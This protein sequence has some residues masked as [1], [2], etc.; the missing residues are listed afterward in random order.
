VGEAR[1]HWTLGPKAGTQRLRVHVGS[2][3]S[4]P[5]LTITASALA[6]N[7]ARLVLVSGDGQRA[8]AGDEL[9]KAIA[10]RVTDRTSNPVAGA[11]VHLA[12]SAGSV[13]DTALLTDSLGLAST[14]WTMGRTV[15]A[16]TLA[17]SVD[18]VPPLRVSARALPGAPANLSFQEPP[19]EGLPGRALRGRI[20]AVVT[21][22]YGNP[23]PNAVVTFSTRSGAVSPMRAAADTAGLVRATWT[24]GA[25]LGEQELTGAVRGTDVDAKLIVQAVTRLSAPVQAGRP[26]ASVSKPAGSKTPPP[27]R[28]RTR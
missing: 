24:L 6:G 26:R 9:S 23:V 28:K 1:A 19:V 4:I 10:V 7:A 11:T 5:P 18:S 13:A 22:V 8:R 25:A 2:A 27:A 16:H 15:G 20:I 12:P 14:R 21:D 17:I 3:R